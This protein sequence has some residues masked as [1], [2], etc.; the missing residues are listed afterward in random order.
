MS[1]EAELQYVRA[2][3]RLERLEWERDVLA[4]QIEEAESELAILLRRRAAVMEMELAGQCPRHG[5]PMPEG[6]DM[7]PLCQQEWE[8]ERRQDR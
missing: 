7:C 6:I 5:E 4:K 8:E 2:G 1:Y 3:E